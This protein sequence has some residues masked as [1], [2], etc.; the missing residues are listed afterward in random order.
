MPWAQARCAQSSGGGDWGSNDQPGPIRRTDR[1]APVSGGDRE[2]PSVAAG[3]QIDRVNDALK[4]LDEGRIGFAALDVRS[5]E[6]PDPSNDLLTGRSDVLLT[7][8]IAPGL[9][10]IGPVRPARV[11]VLEFLGRSLQIAV[12]G[13]RE[14][15]GVI[16]GR[17]VRGEF[18][19]LGE[20]R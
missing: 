6:P 11:G 16:R 10:R 9:E 7:Q 20:I 4:S 8:H 12:P 19:R 13:E 14:A 5:P 2:M 1:R 17:K 15:P 18:D 3:W